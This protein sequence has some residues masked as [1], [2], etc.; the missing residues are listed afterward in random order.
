MKWKDVL[1]GAL[2][3]LAITVFGGIIVYYVTKEPP[4]K[5]SEKLIYSVENPQNFVTKKQR[6]NHSNN[7]NW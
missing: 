4:K 5:I 1:I 3:T 6:N 7:P 2:I